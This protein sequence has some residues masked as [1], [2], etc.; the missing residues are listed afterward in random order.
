MKKMKVNNIE[1]SY[2]LAREGD[3]WCLELSSGAKFHFRAEALGDHSLVLKNKQGQQRMVRIN[4][5]K[6]MAL[7][8]SQFYFLERDQIKL[9]KNQRSEGDMQSPMPGKILKVMASVGDE[10]QQGQSL[11]VMEA[12]KMEHTIKAPFAGKV[13]KINVGEDQMIEGGIELLELEKSE[14]E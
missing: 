3:Y 13:K 12:M 4:K 14:D 11:I 10:V 7:M 1:Y 5:S 2:Q 6:E 8:G 9:T